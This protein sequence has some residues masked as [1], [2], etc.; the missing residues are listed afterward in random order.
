MDLRRSR[1][2]PKSPVTSQAQQRRRSEHRTVEMPRAVSNR[3]TLAVRMGYVGVIALATLTSL[4][5]DP[6][7]SRALQRLP[8]A[9]NTGLAPRDLVDA[10]R[11]IVLF[12]GWGALWVITAPKQRTAIRLTF[13]TRSGFL[14]SFGVEAVQLFSPIRR[15]SILDVTTNTVG[16]LI[17]AV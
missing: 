15:A 14:L 11:N 9:L 1:R 4:R 7:I 17:G 5:L 13:A 8:S 12:A 3:L 16:Y 6:D 2:E 10:I